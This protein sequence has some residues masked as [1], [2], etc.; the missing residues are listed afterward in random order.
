MGRSTFQVSGSP[1]FDSGFP[2]AMT[3]P[4]RIEDS[5]PFK[6]S[7]IALKEFG[8]FNIISWSFSLSKSLSVYI[9]VHLEHHDE[10]IYISGSFKSLTA[11]STDRATGESAHSCTS[12]SKGLASILKQNSNIEQPVNFSRLRAKS[13]TEFEVE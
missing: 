11:I 1:R 7:R 3:Q 13:L 6:Y 8:L 10:G 9:L 5:R 4:M 12:L 2:S